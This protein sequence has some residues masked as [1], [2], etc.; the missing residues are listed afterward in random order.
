M[1]LFTLRE[2]FSTT[3]MKLPKGKTSSV[4][5]GAIRLFFLGKST[6]GKL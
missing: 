1:N 5:C 6:G 4:Y 3:E 2:L